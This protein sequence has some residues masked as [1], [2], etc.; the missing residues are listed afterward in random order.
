MDTVAL[1]WGAAARSW[2]VCATDKFSIE[3]LE[4][5]ADALAVTCT[6]PAFCHT[7]GAASLW[8][9]AAAPDKEENLNHGKQKLL[10]TYFPPFYDFW[11]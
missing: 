2:A 7:T 1:P 4:G 11:G 6:L 10:K 8:K 5:K 9:L 3:E